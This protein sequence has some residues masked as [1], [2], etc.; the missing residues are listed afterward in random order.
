MK[1]MN[2]GKAYIQ[3]TTLH[4]QVQ[5]NQ[6][7]KEGLIQLIPQEQAARL[8]NKTIIYP[9]DEQRRYAIELDVFHQLHCLVSSPLSENL[10][11]EI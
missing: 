2:Y 11:H 6:L 10:E 9:H 3:V 1:L 7:T 5:R 4:A 8:A